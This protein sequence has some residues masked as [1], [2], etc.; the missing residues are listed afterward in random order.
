[1]APLLQLLHNTSLPPVIWNIVANYMR[2]SS[3]LFRVPAFRQYDN[4]HE[5]PFYR[6]PPLPSLQRLRAIRLDMTWH[7][8]GIILS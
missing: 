5:G 1:V 8:Q 7:D 4:S 3:S 6:L 2:P